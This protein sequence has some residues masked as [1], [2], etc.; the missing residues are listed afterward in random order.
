[1][2]LPPP[3]ETQSAQIST[4]EKSPAEQLYWIYVLSRIDAPDIPQ[5]VKQFA[6]DNNCVALM[7]DYHWSNA[8]YRGFNFRGVDVYTCNKNKKNQYI[9]VKDDNIRFSNWLQR[10]KLNKIIFYGY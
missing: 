5:N 3:V 2:D 4:A 10:H 8:K 9:L 6:K 1:M 7:K